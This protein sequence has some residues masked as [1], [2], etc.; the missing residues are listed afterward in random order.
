MLNNMHIHIPPSDFEK[1]YRPKAIIK[2]LSAPRKMD[3]YVKAFKKYKG[4]LMG[5]KDYIDE[6]ISIDEPYAYVKKDTFKDIIDTLVT[7][8]V[9]NIDWKAM[10]TTDVLEFFK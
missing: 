4:V 8:D 1:E 3:Y 9:N 6:V 10:L 2:E 5:H 7:G